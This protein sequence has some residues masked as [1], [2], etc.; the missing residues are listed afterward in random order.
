[1]AQ[2][3]SVQVAALLFDSDGVL[4]DSHEKGIGAW[5]DI[6]SQYALPFDEVVEILAGVRPED[7]LRRYVSGPQL[8]EAVD[9]LEA[10]EIAASTDT[11]P[12]PGALELVASLPL[13]RYAFVTSASKALAVAR[14]REAGFAPPP[15]VITAEDVSYGKPHPE[16][17]LAGIERLGVEPQ[18]CLVFEDSPS[19]GEA[20]KAAG[21]TVVAV[22]GAEWSFE[23]AARVA[24]LR[25]VSARETSDGIE[26]RLR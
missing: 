4:V 12:I 21:A 19:G 3:L 5:R 11:P 25:A 22:G 20:A 14:W 9:R 15:I 2:T 1:M 10:L 18:R 26:V 7:T 8:A 6:C 24:D 16:P 23:P 13:E 17:F